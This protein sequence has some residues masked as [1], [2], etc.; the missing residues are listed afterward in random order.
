MTHELKVWPEYF[1]AI[2]DGRKTFEFRDDDRGFEVGDILDL[3]AWDPAKSE[4]TG[5][6]LLRRV[7]YLLRGTWGLPDGKVILALG[8]P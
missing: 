2:W 5:G 1:D 6:R 4:Y 3:R 8:M 7:T